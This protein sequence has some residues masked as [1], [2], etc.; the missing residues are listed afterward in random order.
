[1]SK[2]YADILFLL[3]KELQY[4][5]K[6][7][8]SCLL[9][10]RLWCETVVP[11][12]WRNPWRYNI[13]Y[14]NK[15][16]LFAIIAFY[17]PIDIKEFLSSQ[18]INFPPISYQYLLF[19]YLS[20]CKSININIIES[21]IPIGSS[22]NYNQFLLQQEF[23]NLLIIN[24]PKLKYLDI[25]S[26]KHQIFCFPGAK[27]CLETLCELDCN[28]SI[29][30]VHFYGL[31]SICQNIQKLVIINDIIKVN[32]GIAKLI[33]V[34][35]NLKSFEWKDDFE[36]DYILGDLY[37]ESLLALEKKADNLDHLKI[38]FQYVEEFEHTLLEEV[39]PK[40]YKSRTLIINDNIYFDQFKMLVYQNIEILYIDYITINSA[41]NI[42]EN[43]GGLLKEILLF[44][45]F[46]YYDFEESFNEDSINFMNKIIKHCPLIEYLTLA[47]SPTK[48][49]FD[50]FEKLLKVCQNLTSLLLFI[51]NFDEKETSEKN[52]E[53]G[54]ELLKV[55]IRSA[56]TNLREIK[57]F[58]DFRF[59]LQALG[60]FLEKWK[61]RPAF[62]IFTTD[63]IYRRED[64][65]NLINKYINVGEK[66]FFKK[67]D[68]SDRQSMNISKRAEKYYQAGCGI[69]EESI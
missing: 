36:E 47:F 67:H 7:L 23:Y 38:F 32:N 2:L 54:A 24:C 59:S 18:G 4:D 49:H 21:I 11:I 37:K 66:D 61:G 62:S 52:L 60:E 33:E 35:G 29:D 1:M 12:L 17:L 57:F 5:S 34:Q 64:Y 44:K 39:L 8:F 63:Y 68:T 26:I 14:K 30:P 10:N 41:S 42:I 69:R 13:N 40:L 50:E 25:Q 56:P 16:Y 31:A 6:S 28:T 27:A 3:F 20:F 53:N 22:I 58:E 45:F 51:F 55:L 15:S 9:V 48:K 65:M 19:D 46:E 43:S